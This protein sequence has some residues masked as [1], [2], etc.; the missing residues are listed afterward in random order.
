MNKQP[1]API[2][3]YDRIAMVGDTLHTD[4]LGGMGAGLKTVLITGYGLFSDG[5]A[6]DAIAATGIA[7]DYIVDTV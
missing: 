4:I 6:A 2:G 1:P 3:S 5:S 7:P